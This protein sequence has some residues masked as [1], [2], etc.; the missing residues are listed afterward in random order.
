[1]VSAFVQCVGV[2]NNWCELRHWDANLLGVV[3]VHHTILRPFKRGQKF[4]DILGK[5]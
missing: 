3:R 2:N 1:M 4:F 5:L